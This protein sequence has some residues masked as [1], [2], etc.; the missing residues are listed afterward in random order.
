M[1]IR[2][3]NGTQFANMVLSGADSLNRHAEHVNSLNVFPVPD[4]D[5]G[6]NMNLTMTAG[7][8]ELK[9]KMS[10]SIA[11]SAEVLSKGLLMGARGN[12]G[13]IL[14][15]LFRGFG[16]GVA[17]LDEVNS[18]QFAH[19]MQSGVD[20][21]YK[22]VVKPVEG[23]ILTVAK[24]TA[25]H[26]VQI[27][28]RTPDLT[29]FMREV[30]AKSK[31]ALAKTPDML[32]VLKQVGVVDSGGQGLVYIY[33]GFLSVLE[34]ADGTFHETAAPT[35]VHTPSAVPAPNLHTSA[36]AKLHTEDIEFLY[37]MEFFIDRTRG[38]SKPFDEDNF[39]KALAKNGDSIILI[40]DDEIIKV[41]VH[42]RK[43][44]EVFDLAMEYGELT[45]MHI[46]NMREQHREIIHGEHGDVSAMPEIFAEIPVQ[47]M[48]IEATPIE[49]PAE[50]LAPYGF[51]AV[52]MG[53]GIRDIFS[54]LGV[55]VVL[56]GG[57]TM[58]PSTQDFIDAIESI[59]A[60]HI[61][62][63]P[64][65]SNIV[66]AAKQAAEIVERDVTVLISKTIPQGIAAAFAFQED[67]S[68]EVNRSAMEDAIAHITSG[69]VTYAVRDTTLDG[70]EIKAGHYMGIVN[71]KI[72]TTTESVT[73]TLQQLVTKMMENNGE[74]VTLLTGEEAKDEDTEALVAWLGEH[75][76]NAEV[77][78][79][80]GGQPIYSYIIS[81]E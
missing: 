13:V 50:E 53:D 45:Q 70:L 23:T 75:Y 7:V 4:G 19:A 11:K 79:H 47:E 62:I 5:T 41:H 1:N 57:Q 46:L 28:R 15:Q 30:V 68:L 65:N 42:S 80:Q 48:T 21:A 34:S 6:T 27:A 71:G 58:N 24:E 55:D 67:E 63:L 31:E 51:I 81:V 16:R 20:T 40:P 29:E 26:A 36:Q 38:A 18:V 61:F 54:S 3:L 56:S 39:R 76:P 17:G 8:T 25:K 37:D 10:A 64:N 9:A 52:A 22:A 77:E 44:G 33:E 74:V 59:S 12:S 73:D 78:V 66:M 35:T 72:V 2:S 14:S 60:Q 69:Q 49:P 32:P 43:P